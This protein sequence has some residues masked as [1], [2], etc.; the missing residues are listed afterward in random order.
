MEDKQENKQELK[1]IIRV[2]NTDLVGS[3]QLF[4]ALTKIK[5]ISFVFANTICNI[6]NIDKTKK[7]GALTEQE[8][9]KLDDIIKNPQKYSIPIWMFNRRKDYE[10]NEDKHLLGPDLRFTQENDIKRLKKIKS[11]RGFRHTDGLPTRGQRTK[12]NFR[13]K[14][15]KTSLGVKR[16]KAK[17]GRV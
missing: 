17:A 3:K 5:G 10:T 6:S 15:G 8:V 14:K 9:S 1:H 2:V 7:A 13:N 4:V 16:K 11:Y 12:A